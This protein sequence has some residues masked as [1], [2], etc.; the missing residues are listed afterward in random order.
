MDRWKRSL[1]LA[2]A[3]FK[4]NLN[5]VQS[6]QLS[7]SKKCMQYK[8]AKYFFQESWLEFDRFYTLSQRIAVLNIYCFSTTIEE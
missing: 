8:M 2:E 4:Q 5:P 3:M 7:A 1:S 6:Q